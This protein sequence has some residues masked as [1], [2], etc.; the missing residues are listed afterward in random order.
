MPAFPYP[1]Q[2][3]RRIRLPDR[4]ITQQSLVLVWRFHLRAARVG[5]SERAAGDG[6]RLG[7]R[8][9]APRSRRA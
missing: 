2:G 6:Q 5:C 1:R 9:G 4:W 3:C 7:T 8:R